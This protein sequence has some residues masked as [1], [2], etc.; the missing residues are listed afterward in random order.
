VFRERQRSEIYSFAHEDEMLE[1]LSVFN[2]VLAQA[3]SPRSHGCC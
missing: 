2:Q 1:W 3:T